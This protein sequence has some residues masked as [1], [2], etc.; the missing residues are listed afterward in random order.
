MSAVAEKILADALQLS[1]P[2]R[3]DLVDQLVDSLDSC[4]DAHGIHGDWKAEI[5]RRMADIDNGRIQLVAWPEALRR[6]LSD[7]EATSA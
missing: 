3:A 1:E 4:G 5:E 6:M 7:N 2:E